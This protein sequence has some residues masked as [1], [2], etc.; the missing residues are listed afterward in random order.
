MCDERGIPV[1]NMEGMQSD[2]TESPE[3]KK[4]ISENAESIV[5]SWMIQG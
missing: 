3:S 5:G 2:T 4:M 1:R